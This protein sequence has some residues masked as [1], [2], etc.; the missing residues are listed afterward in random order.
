MFLMTLGSKAHVSLGLFTGTVLRLDNG[1]NSV[2]QTCSYSSFVDSHYILRDPRTSPWRTHA[3]PATVPMLLIDPC[4]IW[5]L[6]RLGR[7][8]VHDAFFQVFT[9]RG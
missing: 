2:S 4:L 9:H 8:C 5:V 6:L 3:G 7:R 1:C